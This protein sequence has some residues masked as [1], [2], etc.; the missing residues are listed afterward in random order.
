M[1]AAWDH[2]REQ[3]YGRIVLI[4][5]ESGMHGNFGQTNYAAAKVC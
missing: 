4:A 5:S 3:E 2:F 1:R